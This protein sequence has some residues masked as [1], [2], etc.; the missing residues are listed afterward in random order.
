MMKANTP[1]QKAILKALRMLLPLAPY[2]DF[3][4]IMEAAK[5]KH[6]RTLA[7]RDCA[8]LAAIAHIRHRHTDYDMLLAG[9]YDLASARHFVLDDINAVLSDWGAS[10]FVSGEEAELEPD[11][12]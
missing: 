8:F 6:M 10:H 7:P 12:F 9:G 11:D 1:R 5:A 3:A 2:S 4:P